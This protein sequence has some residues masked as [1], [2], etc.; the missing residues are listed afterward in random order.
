LD[1]GTVWTVISIVVHFNIK[2]LL[3]NQITPFLS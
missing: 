1:F 2:L 3:T